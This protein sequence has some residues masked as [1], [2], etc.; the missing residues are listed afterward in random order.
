M[1]IQQKV[2]AGLIPIEG[3]TGSGQNLREL[4]EILSKENVDVSNIKDLSDFR[5]LLLINDWRSIAKGIGQ[6]LFS[7]GKALGPENIAKAL[8]YVSPTAYDLVQE[9]KKYLPVLEDFKADSG[10]WSGD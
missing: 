6:T 5:A 10:I 2:E 7:A 1:I 3:G 4:L 9:Y 8:K